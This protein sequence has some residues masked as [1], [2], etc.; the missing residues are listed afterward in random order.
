MLKLSIKEKYTND[1]KIN[2]I[3]N[4][5]SYYFIVIVKVIVKIKIKLK[6]I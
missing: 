5:L 6:I 2:S 3:F 1:S 4:N